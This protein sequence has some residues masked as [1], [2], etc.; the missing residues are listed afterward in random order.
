[1]ATLELQN[2]TKVFG[3]V[4]AVN[5]I[6]FKVQD[7]EFVT[8][9]GPSGCGKST[10]L[11]L[12]AGLER[13]DSGAI[14]LDGERVN[15]LPPNLRD[16]A[17]VFQDYALYPHMTVFENMAFSLR[18]KKVPMATRKEAVSRVAA[19]LD[20]EPLLDRH[21]RELSGGQRQRV[22]VGRAIVR[23]PKVFLLDEPL[24]NLDE[25][26]RIRMRTELRELFLSL[27]ATTLY[28]THDQEEA[29]SMSDKIAVLHAG[30]LEQFGTPSEIFNAPCNV[31]VASFVGSPPIN[32]VPGTL[33]VEGDG[34]VFRSG[35]SVIRFPH[36]LSARIGHH[37]LEGGMEVIL[38]IRPEHL[39]V[40][41]AGR[42][43]RLPAK[44]ALLEPLG[45]TTAASFELPGGIEIKGIVT[46][47]EQSLKRGDQVDVCILPEKLLVFDGGT[48]KVLTA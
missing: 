9:L 22:A 6:S 10:T 16:M 20:I 29:M 17:M 4:V 41:G 44:V 19:M 5:S 11:N 40:N 47:D 46:T 15:D 1:M 25:R 37:S 24:S 42:G 38:G 27:K 34:Y 43:V 8:L 12:V 21:P 3:K 45:Y 31:F 36:S 7:G 48:Q 28:V 30:V 23:D 26:L 2:V 39:K 35:Q 33:A 13:A 32:L 18:L 14:L